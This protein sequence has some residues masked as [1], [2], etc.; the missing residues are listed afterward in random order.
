MIQDCPE[1]KKFIIG[2]LKEENKE[3]KQKP[4]VQERV[5]AMTHQDAQATSNMVIGIIQI[6]T[7]NARILID[8]NS[9]HSLFQYLLLVYQVC[10]LVAWTLI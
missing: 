5:F 3:Y 9:I 10:L 8:P 7:L 4:R 6:Y 2:K 1:N